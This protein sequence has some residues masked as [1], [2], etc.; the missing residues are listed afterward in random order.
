MPPLDE[1]ALS[2]L[3]KGLK[4]LLP[5]KSV[6]AQGADVP[7]GQPQD[8]ADVAA[9]WGGL[10]VPQ[11]PADVTAIQEFAVQILAAEPLY[12]I[13]TDSEVP[14]CVGAAFQAAGELWKRL[15]ALQKSAGH[16]AGAFATLPAIFGRAA[17]DG[18]KFRTLSEWNDTRRKMMSDWKQ[19]AEFLRAAVDLYDWPDGTVNT[20]ALRDMAD[21]LDGLIDSGYDFRIFQPDTVN[22]GVRLVYRQEW[23]PE[24]YQVGEL[25]HTLPL[26]PGEKVRY[27]T[28]AWQTT[29]TAQEINESTTYSTEEVLS[30]TKRDVKEVV[31][32]SSKKWGLKQDGSGGCNFAV[33]HAEGSTSVTVDRSSES[34]QTKQ[35]FREAI[36]KAAESLRNER[37]VSISVSREAGSESRMTREIQNPNDE[38]TVTYL[39][40]E[41][42]RRYRVNEYLYDVV[43]VVYVAMDVPPSSRIDERWIT[44][45]D[46]ILAGAIL[47]KSFLDPIGF[48]TKEWPGLVDAYDWARQGYRD[49][50]SVVTELKG[51][52]TTIEEG[53]A[54]FDGGG[55]AEM[56]E[57]IRLRLQLQ[58]LGPKLKAAL[59]AEATARQELHAAELTYRRG[60]DKVQRLIGHVRQNILHYMQAIWAAEVPEQRYLRMRSLLYPHVVLRNGS[61][62]IDEWIP[63]AEVVDTEHHLGYIGNY[64]IFRLTRSDNAVVN[65]LGAPFFGNGAVSDPDT[66]KREDIR[67]YCPTDAVFV[68]ALPGTH[69]L[70]ETFKLQHRRIDVE[71]ARQDA[72]QQLVENARRLMLLNE[73]R[74]GDPVVEKAVI[75]ASDTVQQLL[76]GADVGTGGPR[77]RDAAKAGDE[78]GAP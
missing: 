37:K 5:P 42:Q 57:H 7:P 33:W 43:P 67:I 15:Q 61:Y 32:Q 58:A 30:T 60:K 17:P 56:M 47:D 6:D 3:L 28:R 75:A 9:D 69:P 2:A 64:A 71:K 16:R 29:K 26:T 20:D 48:V 77:T 27:E 46:W 14:P 25:L 55:F 53:L 39:F 54:Q 35:A 24:T 36:S 10:I 68:E 13:P 51:Q 59:D 72:L 4:D 78:A 40:Y 19:L 52:I 45:H 76:E 70:L 23:T 41:L 34:R 65:A 49:A 12:A 74:L 44:K 21:Q 63:L 50:Q 8:P 73:L 66:A 18:G 22:V 38:I 1:Q 11:G 62:V 31:D